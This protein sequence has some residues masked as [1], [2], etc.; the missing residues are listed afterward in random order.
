M[1]GGGQR[2]KGKGQ[3]AKGEAGCRFDLD[4]YKIRGQLKIERY[5][6]GN[7]CFGKVIVF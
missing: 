2:A 6:N 5:E 3:R 1:K 4:L 7:I